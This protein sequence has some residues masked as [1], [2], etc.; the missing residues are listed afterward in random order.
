MSNA[1][2]ATVVILGLMLGLHGL[3]TQCLRGTL[4]R[5]RPEILRALADVLRTLWPWST[6]HSPHPRG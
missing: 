6:D 3:I 5:E 1:E 2:V 4:P